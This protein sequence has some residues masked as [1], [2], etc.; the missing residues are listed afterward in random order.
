MTSKKRLFEVLSSEVRLA[1][2]PSLPV[3]RPALT[4]DLVDDGQVADMDTF[5]EW[6]HG[7]GQPWDRRAWQ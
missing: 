7:H 6:P 3:S 2:W 1:L 5:L 4:M